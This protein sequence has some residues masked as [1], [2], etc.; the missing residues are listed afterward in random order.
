MRTTQE[1][2][3]EIRDNAIYLDEN[4]V[5]I[6]DYTGDIFRIY[7]KNKE[8]EANDGIP[9]AAI[10]DAGTLPRFKYDRINWMLLNFD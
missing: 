8:Y 10:Q 5:D 7:T 2:D 6:I 4:F 9:P 3:T 1:L